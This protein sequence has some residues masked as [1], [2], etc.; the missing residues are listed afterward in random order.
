M[1]KREP[2]TGEAL[3]KLLHSSNYSDRA[4]AAYLAGYDSEKQ[5]WKA[6]REALAEQA[7]AL[8]K[9]AVERETQ[10]YWYECCLEY[11]GEGEAYEIA[12]TWTQDE[13]VTADNCE[14]DEVLFYLAGAPFP[15]NYDPEKLNFSQIQVY[16]E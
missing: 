12:Y 3:L 14:S 4:T 11:D 6:E 16:E 8:E 7:R 9:Q 13:P 10:S 15:D 1:P 5:L 2:L